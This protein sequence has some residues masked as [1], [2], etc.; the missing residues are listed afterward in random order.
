[1]SVGE[2]DGLLDRTHHGAAA[3]DDV[4]DIDHDGLAGGDAALRFV[5]DE[6][7]RGIAAARRPAQARGLRGVPIA[8]LGAYG[9]AR[10]ARLVQ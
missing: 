7:E 9:K 3:Q 4:A 6:L 5:E 8:D 1:M 2:A 10:L